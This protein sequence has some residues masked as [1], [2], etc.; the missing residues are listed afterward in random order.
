MIVKAFWEYLSINRFE[1]WFTVLANAIPE[2]FIAIVFG[3]IIYR[4]ISRSEKNADKKAIELE[5]LKN[6]E[7]KIFD[8]LT[9]IKMELTDIDY[10][11]NDY[12]SKNSLHQYIYLYTDFWETLKSG[13]ELPSLF[14]PTLIQFLSIYYSKATE[15]NSLYDKYLRIRLLNNDYIIEDIEKT[16]REKIQSLVNISDKGNGLVFQ[17]VDEFINISD[18][19]LEP[20]RKSSEDKIIPLFKE[21]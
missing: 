3:I 15:I 7:Q 20:Y 10:K 6:R 21:G 5:G 13:G 11:I 18:K 1:F 19:N 14:N 16:F 8:Y 4:Y 12:H 17:I 2:I 9:S